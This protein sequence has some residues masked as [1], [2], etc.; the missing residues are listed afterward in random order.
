MKDALK[1]EL[2]ISQPRINIHANLSWPI[3]MK[4]M[5]KKVPAKLAL[6]QKLDL[7]LK[8]HFINMEG[9]IL[10][11]FVRFYF[12]P[13]NKILVFKFNLALVE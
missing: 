2:K 4:L 11:I 5:W 6:A 10:L 3:I 13:R 12:C 9:E 1:L 7:H 8:E